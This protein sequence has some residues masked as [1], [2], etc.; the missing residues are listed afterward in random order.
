MRNIVP[1]IFDTL[2]TFGLI[3]VATISDSDIAD[4]VVIGI[5][6]ATEVMVSGIEC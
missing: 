6:L 4:S 1:Y 3:Q 2:N 5:S